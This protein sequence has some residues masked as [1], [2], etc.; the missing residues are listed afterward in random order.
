MAAISS[1]EKELLTAFDNVLNRLMQDDPLTQ[2]VIGGEL[3]DTIRR[4]VIPA[5]AKVRRAGVRTLVGQGMY[6]KDIAKAAGVSTT[7]IDQIAKG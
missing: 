7:R 6:Y 3:Y 1:Y 5:V 4:D 2:I